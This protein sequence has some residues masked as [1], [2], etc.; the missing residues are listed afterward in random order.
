MDTWHVR[1]NA[2]GKKTKNEMFPLCQEKCW[3]R[4]Q[5]RNVRFVVLLRTLQKIPEQIL[6]RALLEGCKSN[7]LFIKVSKFFLWFTVLN[8]VWILTFKLCQVCFWLFRLRGLSGNCKYTTLS[9]PQNFVCFWSVG[10]WNSHTQDQKKKFFMEFWQFLELWLIV[11]VYFILCWYFI[12]IILHWFE[13]SN[14]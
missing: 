11:N 3:L 12:Q 5:R 4:N 2:W 7:S 6:F 10:G 8:H 14:H 1:H 9:P 13:E